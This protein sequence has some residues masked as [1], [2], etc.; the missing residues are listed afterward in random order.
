MKKKPGEKEKL[1]PRNKF[2]S[3]F[4]KLLRVFKIFHSPTKHEWKR[5]GLLYGILIY[6]EEAVKT[7]NGTIFWDIT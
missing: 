7:R 2:E 4:Q 5:V 1:Q 3:V 6:F